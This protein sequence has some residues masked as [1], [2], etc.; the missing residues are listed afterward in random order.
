MMSKSEQGHPM[1]CQMQVGWVKI[2]NFWHIVQY[3]LRAVQDRCKVS[4]KVEQQV[5]CTV[6]NGYIAGDCD[7]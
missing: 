6:S 7:P 2:G 1:G 3:N 5:V 4:V